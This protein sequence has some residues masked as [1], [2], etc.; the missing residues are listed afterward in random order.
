MGVQV[1][2]RPVLNKYVGGGTVAMQGDGT[3]TSG[4]SGSGKDLAGPGSTYWD[5]TNEVMWVNKGTRAAPY[6][7]PITPVGHSGLWGIQTDFR[8]QVGIS[9]TDTG[10][11]AVIAGSGLRIYGQGKAEVADSGA[12]AQAAA[13]GWPTGAMRFSTTNEAAH[14]IAFG[15]L[16]GVYQPD[17]HGIGIVEVLVAQVT[18]ITDRAFFCGFLGTA[19]DALDPAVTGATTVATLVQ[20]DLFGAHWDSG[21]TD[22]D[23]IYGVENKSNASATQDLTVSGDTSTNQAAAGTYQRYRVEVGPVDSTGLI[24]PGRIFVDRVQIYS[25]ANVLDEDEEHAFVCYLESNAAA[26]KDMDVREVLMCATGR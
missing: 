20:D 4:T 3:P 5:Y 9:V 23:R 7:H 11:A 15:S 14:T 17:Q 25:S 18:A 8:D 10:A 24:V 12:V 13:E 21:Y 2:R 1:E 22:A 19:A 26:G 16:A 6:W